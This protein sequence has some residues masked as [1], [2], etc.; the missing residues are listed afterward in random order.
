M[1]IKIIF[2]TSTVSAYARGSI[3]AGELVATITEDN[4]RIG[5]PVTCLAEAYGSA[6]GTER[7][8]LALLI[9][10]LPAVEVLPLEASDVPLVG[11]LSRSSSIGVGHAVATAARANAY[12]ATADRARL[13]R[14]GVDEHLIIDLDG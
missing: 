10:A 2:D 4:D 13:A 7:D 3:A 5:V 14:L 6:T 8:L 9:T 11:E 12:L 1:T